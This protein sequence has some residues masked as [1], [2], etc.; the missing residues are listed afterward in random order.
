LL[1]VN[2]PNIGPLLCS[3]WRTTCV[4]AAN[5]RL[6]GH[7]VKLSEYVGHGLT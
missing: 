6:S 2:F 7:F 5:D 4:L 3:A 1:I